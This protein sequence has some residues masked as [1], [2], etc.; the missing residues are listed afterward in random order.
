MTPDEMSGVILSQLAKDLKISKDSSR[1]LPSS[2][3]KG[4]E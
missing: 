1:S 4:S 2:E 3:A